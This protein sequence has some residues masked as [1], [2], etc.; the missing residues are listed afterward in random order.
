MPVFTSVGLALGAPIASAAAVGVAA[1]SLAA[2]A[3]STYQSI[4]AQKDAAYQ[5]RVTAGET[6]AAAEKQYAAEQQK[7]DVINVR[8]VRQQ[9]REQRMAQSSMLNMGAQT[10]GM[11]SSGLAG[12]MGSVGSQAA[13]N[14]SFMAQTAEA[15]TAIGGAALEGAQAQSRGGAAIAQAQ[16]NA[17]VWGAVGQLSGTI[18]TNMGGF[19][20]M[21][22]T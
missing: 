20:A 2:T 4:G 21:K 18:F 22:T 10:G 19:K 11:G 16:S 5:A 13:G 7:A 14:L 1:T 6:Q 12:G 3:A 17:A 15:N 9:I 8:S